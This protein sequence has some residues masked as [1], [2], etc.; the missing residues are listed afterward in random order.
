MVFLIATAHSAIAAS[1][2]GFSDSADVHLMFNP[3][4]YDGRMIQ[5][6]EKYINQLLQMR[7]KFYRSI[8]CL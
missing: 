4:S 3:L 7:W 2:T 8:N 6:S 1:K 5:R